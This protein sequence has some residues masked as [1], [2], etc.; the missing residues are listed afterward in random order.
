[1][2]SAP[3]DRMVGDGHAFHE[4]LFTLFPREK[5]AHER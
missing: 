1:M 3:R 5:S 2:V 4:A